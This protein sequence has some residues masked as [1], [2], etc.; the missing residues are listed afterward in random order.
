MMRWVQEGSR[1]GR[2][3]STSGPPN[4]GKSIPGAVSAPTVVRRVRCM[5]LT[6]ILFPGQGSQ[7]PEMR[8][9]VAELASGSAR[10]SSP[11][12]SARIR[13][14]APRTATQV[15]AARDLLRQPR[16]LARARIS[17]R[18]FHGRPLAGRAGGAGGRRSALDE[19]DGL[20][21]VALRGRLMHEAGTRATGMVAL[22]G[23]APPSTRPSSR[24]AT[25]SR[26]RTTTRPSRS[27]SPVS[28][29]ALPPMPRRAKELGLRAMELPVTRRVPLADDGAG[30]PRVRRG[31]RAR[32]DRG[33]AGAGAVSA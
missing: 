11:R 22:L 12:W 8:D 24:P 33:A 17:G 10:R 9:H 16:R 5:G 28:A 21:L 32:G 13:S 15:R 6:A 26:W 14:R 19:R 1:G 31:P 27:C 29:R 20:E 25:G 4:G 2:H 23:P 7:T 18:R 30:G 3:W